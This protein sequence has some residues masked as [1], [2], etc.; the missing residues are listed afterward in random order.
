MVVVT[1]MLI[2]MVMQILMHM[3]FADADAV[4]SAFKPLACGPDATR[5]R[6][7]PFRVVMGRRLCR[8][9]SQSIYSVI[10]VRLEQAFQFRHGKLRPGFLASVR[11]ARPSFA[12]IVAGLRIFNVTG[13]MPH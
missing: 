3:T 13:N 8:R 2:K 10:V 5:H 12:G 6:S 9:A 1:M 7:R 11:H 4:C